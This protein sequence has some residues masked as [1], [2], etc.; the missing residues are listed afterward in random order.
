MPEEWENFVVEVD[1]SVV[2]VR[3]NRKRIYRTL[4][5]KI[6]GG[7]CRSKYTGS[8]YDLEIDVESDTSVRRLEFEGP[9][10]ISAGDTIRAYIISADK[11]RHQTTERRH[12]YDDGIRYTWEERDLNETEHPIRIDKLEGQSVIATY[13]N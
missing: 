9:W 7:T 3:G 8:R 13:E 12:A 2:G 4:G 10:P 11:V 6:V 5:E 1:C